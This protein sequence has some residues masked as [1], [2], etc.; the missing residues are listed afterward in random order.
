ME[1]LSRSL[2]PYKGI[3]G[4]VASVVTIAQFFSGG[5]ICKDI[6]NR[7]TTAGVSAMPFVGGLVM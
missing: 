2:Q 5:V 3:I 1:G 7:K 6:Y 4:S